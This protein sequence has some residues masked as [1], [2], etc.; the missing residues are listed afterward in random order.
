MVRRS[1]GKGTVADP[2]SFNGRERLALEALVDRLRGVDYLSL[3]RSV[4]HC[5]AGLQC[6]CMLL[7]AYRFA[8]TTVVVLSAA[9]G[10]FQP[11]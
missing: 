10:R 2:V 1:M 5:Y 8:T 3:L 4:V 6:T 7:S 9:A 11:R